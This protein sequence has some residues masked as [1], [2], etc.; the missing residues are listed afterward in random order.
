MATERGNPAAGANTMVCA[1]SALID[2]QIAVS[3]LTATAV[4][5]VEALNLAT[6]AGTAL[7]I[8][9][10]GPNATRVYARAHGLALTAAVTSPVVQLWSG[11][12][13]GTIPPSTFA[14]LVG[15]DLWRIDTD[16]SDAAGI[17][18]TIPGSPSTSNMVQQTRSSVVHRWTDWATNDG[19][20]FDL[21]GGNIV[22]M[23]HTTAASVTAT[24]LYGE[25]GLLN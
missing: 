11:R 23:A 18:L 3:N 2:W 22:I 14:D 13:T 12:W 8:I 17:T 7:N 15:T 1:A 21:K 5:A 6:Y 20:G 10:A 24:A 4:T 9:M 19:Q 25:V 16:D